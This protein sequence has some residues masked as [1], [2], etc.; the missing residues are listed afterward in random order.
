MVLGLFLS[1]GYRN[2]LI[3]KHW[4]NLST[5]KLLFKVF[6]SN[7]V[8]SIVYT[9]G[10]YLLRTS[11]LFNLSFPLTFSSIMGTYVAVF[12]LFGIWNA[13][14]FSW[15][16]IERNRQL[17]LNRL[18]MESELKDL[19]IKTIK[20]NLQPHFI[21]NSLNSIRALVDENPKLARE[22]VTKISNIL[23]NSIAQ[24]NELDTVEN[25]INLVDDYIGLESIR[26]EERL[27]FSKSIDPLT[28]P[29]MIPTMMLQTLV[30]N[31]VKHGISAN[32]DGGEIHLETR[33]EDHKLFIIIRNTGTLNKEK[34]HTDSLSF[35]LN[36]TKQRLAYFY[37][38]KATFEIIQDHDVVKTSIIIQQEN[39][40]L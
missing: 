38:D 15:N 14:Y 12:F 8:I 28:L 26:F 25:E 6:L 40:S 1:H 10:Y 13:L 29:L 33:L 2:L 31:A 23:R 9:L 20:A 21:F 36:A 4:L 27:R 34:T 24:K 19:E 35:G 37:Q 18:R 7:T 32:E 30:E 3:Q 11:I 5:E 16:Y 17:L 22:A 39:N